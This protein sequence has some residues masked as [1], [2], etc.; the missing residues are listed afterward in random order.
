MKYA[1]PLATL[2]TLALCAGAVA[3][4]EP[5]KHIELEEAAIAS[6][7]RSLGARSSTITSKYV[8]KGAPPFN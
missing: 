1:K 4:E 6:E 3:A 5:M 7:E 2:L 8:L